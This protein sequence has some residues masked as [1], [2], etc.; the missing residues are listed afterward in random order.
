MMTQ[1]TDSKRLRALQR[2]G[3]LDTDREAAFDNLT[4]LAKGIL[5]VPVAL[6]SLVDAD[7]QWFKSAEGLHEPWASRR[8]TP[9]SHSFCKHVVESGDTFV[10]HDARNHPLVKDNL[11]IGEI[12]V[13]AYLGMPLVLPGG[14][15]IGSLCAIDSK[16]RVWTDDD[17][18]LLRELARCVMAEI[19]IRDQSDHARTIQGRLVAWSRPLVAGLAGLAFASCA[20]SVEM[21]P[22]VLIAAFVASAGVLF[23]YRRR[24]VPINIASGLT[25]AVVAAS[26]TALFAAAAPVEWLPV[27]LTSMTTFTVLWL[28]IW[29]NV[30][31]LMGGAALGITAA[32]LAPGAATERLPALLFNVL[33]VLAFACLLAHFLKKALRAHEVASDAASSSR[34]A[35]E[36]LTTREVTSRVSQEQRRAELEQSVEQLRRSIGNILNGLEERNAQVQE[37][38]EHVATLTRYA[39]ASVSVTSA[40]A[41]QSVVKM[42]TIARAADNLF[43]SIKD[44]GSCSEHSVKITQKLAQDVQHARSTVESLA[45]RANAVTTVV[46]IIGDL[47]RQTNLLALNA[48]IEAARAG[49]SGR[50]FAVVASEVKSLASQTAAAAETIGD[51]VA[52]VQSSVRDVVAM[53]GAVTERMIAVAQDSEA[54]TKAVADQISATSVIHRSI[55]EMEALNLRTAADMAAISKSSDEAL[56]GTAHIAETTGELVSQ[57]RLITAKLDAFAV[58]VVPL[59]EAS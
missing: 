26:A 32:M 24:Q 7:R 56:E 37:A 16:P 49:H 6:I 40:N 11:A 27:L 54:V 4:R 42:R 23:S 46:D 14:T 22:V 47:T 12:G 17:C 51:Q 39:S 44:V 52:N 50:G 55:N 53:I 43:N 57:N 45:H 35:M 18:T 25:T 15:V 30:G 33:P 3:L 28:I 41:T 8:E 13:E 21:A 36:T 58:S 1:V 20:A 10:V 31:V 59:P 19:V 34:L 5:G 48:T 38:A 29:L 2:T 9:L